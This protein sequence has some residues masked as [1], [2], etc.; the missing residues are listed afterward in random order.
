MTVQKS[1]MLM[2]VVI[3]L[4]AGLLA[5]GV[6]VLLLP[7]AGWWLAAL[8][9]L[10]VITGGQILVLRWERRHPRPDRDAGP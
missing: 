1:T 2:R 4:T 9:G 5:F 10:L 7:T 6:I 3:G 8:G